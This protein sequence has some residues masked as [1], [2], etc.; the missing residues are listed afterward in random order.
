MAP[1][2]CSCTWPAPPRPTPGW[3]RAR[4]LAAA[5]FPVLV[6]RCGPGLAVAQEFFRWEV[7][8]AI[9]AAVLGVNPFDQPDVE[10]SKARTRALSVAA[11]PAAVAGGGELLRVEGAL[12]FHGEPASSPSA[13]A[14]L[15]AHLAHAA[16]AGDY[17]ALLAY[18]PRDA[19]CESWL[20]GARGDIMRATG[21][22]TQGGFG[23]RY[24]HSCGQ[25]HK[26]GRAGGRFLF[27]T[28]QAPGE[29]VAP[30]HAADFGATQR[31]QAF[32]DM[33]EL[34]ARGRRCLRVHISG[35][36]HAGLAQL[37][38]LLRQALAPGVAGHPGRARHAAAAMPLSGAARV[39]HR[40]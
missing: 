8:T 6:C 18:L 27:I 24:L 20:A 3:P 25:L 26:G 2:G 36:L 4:E 28:A 23:P 35:D 15:A 7:A 32:G 17:V 38:D 10:A 14:L 34:R 40:R 21:V 22:A 5:G 31:A 33:E 29:L 37:G 12:A 13:A 16:R 39:P 11:G 19:A 30:G 9:A 1:T